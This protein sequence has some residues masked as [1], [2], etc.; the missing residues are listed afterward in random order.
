MCLNVVLCFHFSVAIEIV[1]SSIKAQQ[2]LSKGRRVFPHQGSVK[3]VQTSCRM[4]IPGLPS[5]RHEDKAPAS[6]K[7]LR[8]KKAVP[9][10]DPPSI[11]N[12]NQLYQFFDNRSISVFFIHAVLS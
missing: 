12:I 11:E 4:S 3:C 6:P 5:S 9:D 1:Q 10:A 8:D 2:L 7:V